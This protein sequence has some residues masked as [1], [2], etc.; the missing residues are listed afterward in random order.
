LPTVLIFAQ[1][2]S[3]DTGDKA[4]SASE[5]LPAQ[6][7]KLQDVAEK[8][9]PSKSS[10]TGNGDST[11]Q[12]ELET[13]SNDNSIM[14]DMTDE[15]GFATS[16][17]VI[18]LTQPGGDEQD[19]DDEQDEFLFP[20]VSTQRGQQQSCFVRLFGIESVCACVRLVSEQY[21]DCP[22][23]EQ[24]QQQQKQRVCSSFCNRR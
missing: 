23:Q 12:E 11:M 5:P 21:Q 1:H 2:Q 8:A 16:S 10:G 3:L 7:S 9:A 19:Y 18:P 20:H 22:V 6:D 4:T 17:P 24:Q 14:H 13:H 15:T